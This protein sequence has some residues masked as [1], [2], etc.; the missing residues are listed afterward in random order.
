MRRSFSL[1]QLRPSGTLYCSD[2]RVRQQDRRSVPSPPPPQAPAAP[3]SPL[4]LQAQRR[5]Q[6]AT[7]QAQLEITRREL[8]AAQLTVTKLTHTHI[9]YYEDLL[10]RL[11]TTD[12]AAQEA[13]TSIRYTALALHCSQDVLE[14]E[15]RRIL[16]I[17]LNVEKDRGTTAD[18]GRS[19]ATDASIDAAAVEAAARRFIRAN[20][21]YR[22]V[23]VATASAEG[24]PART[25][26]QGND[27]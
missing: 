7:L 10:R 16:A 4:H 13:A 22:P 27:S 14:K 24:E 1:Q 2:K 19:A 3:P 18:E 20:I 25:G 17:G 26:A 15:L 23:S 6:D 5:Q 9:P 21:G 12:K 8:L 11:E